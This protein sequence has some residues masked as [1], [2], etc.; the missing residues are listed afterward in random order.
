MVLP[1]MW[2]V[3]HIWAHILCEKSG[4][5]SKAWL[6]FAFDGFV[7]TETWN[8]YSTNRV[9]RTGHFLLKICQSWID[10]VPP[11]VSRS[12]LKQ[13]VIVFTSKSRAQQL[14]VQKV[15]QQP[16]MPKVSTSQK[17]GK[18]GREEGSNEGQQK[19]EASAKLSVSSSHTNRNWKW[20]G[21][22]R[23]G[24]YLCRPKHPLAGAFHGRYLRTP[25]PSFL[26]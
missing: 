18:P 14:G 3:Q 17:L 19:I 25:V 4:E 9:G 15:C 11:E 6:P 16:C 20:S 13:H 2:L 8:R 7:D 22:C 5:G 12:S 24:T 26:I 1:E 23:G 21:K 10:S